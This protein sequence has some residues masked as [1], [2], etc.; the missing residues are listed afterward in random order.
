[1]SDAQATPIYLCPKVATPPA[2]DGSLDDAIWQTVPPVRLVLTQTGQPTG[3]ETIIRMCWDDDNLYISYACEDEDVW[4]TYTQRDDPIYNE[5]VCEAFICPSCDL[6]S[7]FEINVSPRN[8]VFDALIFS[9]KHEKGKKTDV[10]WDCEGLRTAVVVDGTLDCRTDKDRAWYA[11]M[12]IP[13]KGLDR[14]TPKLGEQWRANL[15]RIE[16]SPLELQA[17]SPT[18]CDPP[19]F[20]VPDRFGTIIFQQ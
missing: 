19:N 4:S 16:R 5:E 11:Q 17:W 12:S 1:M 10:S 18:L 15:Y 6:T 14:P 7:Y 2:I 8:V 9:P 20:H 3:K 13:F